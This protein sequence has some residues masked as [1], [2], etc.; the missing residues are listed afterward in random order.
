MLYNKVIIFI[1][2]LLLSGCASQHGV[3]IPPNGGAGIT[4]NKQVW[5][6][7][8]HESYLK[9]SQSF[10]D[11]QEN[12]FL[13]V[14]N[15]GYWLTNTNGKI[16]QLVYSLDINNK[17]VLPQSKVYTRSSF[18]NPEDKNNPFV[19][20]GTLD[21]TIGSSHI[22]HATVNNVKLNEEYIM[23]F[24][25]YSDSNR[26]KLLT[27]ISQKIVSP[28]DNTNGCVKFTN[29]YMHEIFGNIRDPKGRLIPIDKLII[30]C[31]RD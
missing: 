31:V 30:N 18:T 16:S 17:K 12:K 6:S 19:Y 28:V 21:N 29:E 11:A 4:V 2:L 13:K 22:T 26:T 14:I 24:Y 5:V 9:Y 27:Y 23:S 8:I 1:G 15:A 20:T 25:V 3:V 10:P 7:G